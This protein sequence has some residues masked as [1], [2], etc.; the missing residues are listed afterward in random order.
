MLM[1]SLF[2]GDLK[3][4]LDILSVILS[5]ISTMK[6]KS[7]R[8]TEAHKLSGCPNF[9]RTGSIQG[10]K[11]MYYGKD[12]K[13]ICCGSWIYNCTTESALNLYNSLP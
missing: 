6:T 2:L 5:T 8:K 1:V 12:A 3:T 4:S 9:S 7:A 11:Q 13:L 10:M